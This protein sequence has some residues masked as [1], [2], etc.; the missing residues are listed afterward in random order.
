MKAIR[1]SGS[2][3]TVTSGEKVRYFM[4]TIQWCDALMAQ[5]EKTGTCDPPPASLE[6]TLRCVLDSGWKDKR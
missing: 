6:L 5:I 1:E 3:V 2:E 4:G